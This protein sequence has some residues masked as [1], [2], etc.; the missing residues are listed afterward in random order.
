MKWVLGVTWWII[1]VW[2]LLAVREN[3][4]DEM[5]DDSRW[6]IGYPISCIAITILVFGAA[7]LLARLMQ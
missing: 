7:Y 3:N 2:S 5:K 6:N 1:L 4:E